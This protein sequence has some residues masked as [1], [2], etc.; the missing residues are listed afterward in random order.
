MKINFKERLKILS[1]TYAAVTFGLIASLFLYSLHLF[2]L[3]F[4]MTA[5][6]AFVIVTIFDFFV[7]AVVDETTITPS[8]FL[9]KIVKLKLK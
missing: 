2:T 8:K 1:Y 7:L 3:N 6:L 9:P 5:I 4:W